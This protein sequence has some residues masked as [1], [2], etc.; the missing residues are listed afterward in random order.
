MEKIKMKLNIL[1]SCGLVVSALFV[2]SLAGCDAFDPGN[3]GGT[4]EPSVVPGT[5]VP[6]SIPTGVPTATPTAF[7]TETPTPTTTVPGTPTPGPWTITASAGPNGSIAP[8]GDVIVNDGDD[9]SFTIAADNG[10][11]ILDVVVDTVSMNAVSS[12]T[13]YT[14]T[15]NHTIDATFEM[16]PTPTPTDPPTPPPTPT[17]NTPPAPCFTIYPSQ[18]DIATTFQCDA[19]CSSDAQDLVSALQVQWDWENDG[20]WDTPYTTTKT[21]THKYTTPGTYTIRLRVRDTGLLTNETTQNLSVQ[22]SGGI[23]IIQ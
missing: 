12:Y 23:I 7:P 3:P 4:P 16:D 19:S 6:T 9:Q 8:S 14:V 17:P 18:G 15:A 20:T 1:V 11:Y 10:F 22:S 21:A 2:F 5:P 13:F